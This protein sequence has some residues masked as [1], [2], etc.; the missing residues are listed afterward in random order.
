M[1]KEIKTMKPFNLRQ[2]KLNPLF[3]PKIT[4]HRFLN[5]RLIS[6]SNLLRFVQK[7]LEEQFKIPK[8]F[9]WDPFYKAYSEKTSLEREKTR[10][11]FPEAKE[12][13][14]ETVALV[15]FCFDLEKKK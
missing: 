7:I 11:S 12:K 8:E 10:Y 6:H 3:K 4:H 1:I 5:E 13:A 2:V 9:N 14:I 15:A